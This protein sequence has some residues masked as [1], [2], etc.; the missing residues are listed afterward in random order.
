MFDES[1]KQAPKGAKKQKKGE[2]SDFVIHVMP[3][4][5]KQKKTVV[6][7]EKRPVVKAAPKPVPKPTPK[8]VPPKQPVKKPVTPVKKKSKL[9][10][11]LAIAGILFVIAIAVLGWVA[12]QGIEEEEVVEGEIIEEEV[13]VEE[14]EIRPGSD[15]DSDGLSDIEE[16]MYGTDARDPDSDGDTFLDGNEVF[17]RYSPLGEAPQTLLDTGSVEE[18]E[19]EDLGFTLTYPTQWTVAAE[20]DSEFQETEE[21]I[22]RTN[23]TATIRLTASSL[24]D[25]VFEDWYAENSF[26]E[27]EYDDLDTTLTKEGYVAYMSPD[28]LLAYVEAEGRVYVFQYDLSDEI[29]IVYLQTFQMMINS[30]LA[31]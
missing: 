24:E 4:A 7:E 6:K 28:E 5:F 25:L 26:G 8:P 19:S 23:S 11:I 21:V 12:L 10:W 30:F 27:G 20:V 29:E 2:L 9:P 16:V 13:I 31:Q 15:L 1:Q 3:E 14:E 22:F 18:Y 17:H